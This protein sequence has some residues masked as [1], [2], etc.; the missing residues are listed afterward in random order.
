MPEEAGL[1]KSDSDAFLSALI[2]IWATQHNPV[3]ELAVLGC[4]VYYDQT[5]GP[6]VFGIEAAKPQRLISHSLHY[7]PGGTDQFGTRGEV[8]GASRAN[9][10]VERFVVRKR[11][12]T[13]LALRDLRNPAGIRHSQRF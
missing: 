10:D 6:G 9:L 8:V 13:H 5:I 12:V 7:L 11:L 2:G 4:L 1:G 3:V